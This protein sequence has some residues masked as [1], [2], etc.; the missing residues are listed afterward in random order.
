M[1]PLVTCVLCTTVE[2]VVATGVGLVSVVVVIV[3]VAGAGVITGAGAG[4]GA[5]AVTTT[6]VGTTGSAG[7]VTTTGG[8][9]TG[10]GVT[11]PAAASAA[12]VIAPWVPVPSIVVFVVTLRPLRLVLVFFVTSMWFFVVS[13]V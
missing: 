8:V 10:G 5:G 6:T 13:V 1:V 11:L 2:D 4:S 9:T 3:V 7:G 12:L